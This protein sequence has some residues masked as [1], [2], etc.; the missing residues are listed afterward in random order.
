MSEHA[1][2]ITSTEEKI[3]FL[4]MILII[5]GFIVV[6]AITSTIIKLHIRNQE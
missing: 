4:E 5:K 6:A 3:P 2:I 1:L